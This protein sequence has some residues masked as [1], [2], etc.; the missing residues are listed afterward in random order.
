MNDDYK[1]LMTA[2]QA[3]LKWTDQKFDVSPFLNAPAEPFHATA[4]GAIF[5]A[6]CM[7]VLPLLKDEVVDTVFCGPT[8]QSRQGV[9][10]EH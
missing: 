2:G 4:H 3:L 7:T 9:R 10:Q 1:Y 6:D 5:D 8:I